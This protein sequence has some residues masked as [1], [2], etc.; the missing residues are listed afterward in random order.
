MFFLQTL[1]FNNLST[2]DG[3]S[4]NKVVSVIQD[5]TGFLWFGTEDG[6]NRFDGY[7]FKVFR[8]NPADSNSI[9]SNNIWSLFEDD[10]GNIWIGT[11]SGE[12]N[13]Y[14][15]K[16]DIFE[17][18][19][20]KS[21][22][23]Q[24]NSIN[25]IYSDKDG[26]VWIGSYQSGLYRF[27]IKTGELKNWNYD[28]GDPHSLS[29]NFVTS[30]IE[31]NFG[32][33]WIATYNGLNK[34][35]PEAN[36]DSFTQFY[37][38]SKNENSLSSNL[39]WSI[40]KSEFDPNLMWLGTANGLVSLN[41][42]ENIFS[43]IPLSE[44]KSLQ[45]GNSVSYVVEEKINNKTQLWVGTYGGLVKLDM[46]N[47]VSQ[48]FIKREN[49]PTSIINNQINRTI[50][51]RSGVIWIATEN[52]ISSISTKGF[53]FNNYFNE[54][55]IAGEL[56]NLLEVN[57]KCI[58]QNRNGSVF[59][60]TSD[61]IYSIN[62]FDKQPEFKKF[63]NTNGLNVWS[64]AVDVSNNLW[65][66]T[67]GQGLKKLNL[68]S[69]TLNNFDIE[70]PTFKTSAFD[71]L[72][73]LFIDK[74]NKLWIG[75]WGG[76]LARL[77]PET[78]EYKIWITESG[79]PK[80]ISHNDVWAIHQDGKGRIWIGTNGGG[81]NLAYLPTG[82]AGRQAGLFD[83]S[84]EGKFQR[85]IEVRNKSEQLSSNSIYSICESL[86]GK[87]SQ[88]DET[89]L[90]IGTSNGLNK[91]IIKNSSNLFDLSLLDVEVNYYS[92]QNGLA[93]N[94]VKSILEDEN[95]NLWIGT[96]SGISFFNVESGSFINY[97]NSDGVIGNDFNSGSALFSDAGLMFFGSAIGLNIF[98]PNQIK[99]SSYKPP[100]VFTDF[101][102]FNQPVKIGINSVLKQSIL[103]TKEIELAYSQNVFSFQFSA[104]DYNSPQS[105]QYAYMMEGF[106]KDWIY[107]EHRRFITYTNLDP[108]GYIFKVKSTNSDGVWNEDFKYISVTINQPWWRT[109]WAY[110][111]YI[112]LIVVGIFSARKIERN[113][114]RITKRIKDA[115]V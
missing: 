92:T 65:I 17:H 79:N 25:E 85:W 26:I 111:I 105:I 9:S 62:F 53:K 58:I 99:Q 8:N 2:K 102:I 76:G 1:H 55:N 14:D 24:E 52:G 10:E 70:S 108:G 31:D 59:F 114:S 30:I 94:A 39:I 89:I 86:N 72:K 103:D 22:N 21:E 57:V 33:L 93:D 13:R 48:R 109:G 82:Q 5:K 12:L 97:S 71:Y 63:N 16:K 29:N 15:V 23:I 18:W 49:D 19:K 106:D 80:S 45:F 28:P 104:L 6:L 43:K 46:V 68:K 84:G 74:Y 77:I 35:N 40:K 67:Y 50:R 73:S 54:K 34:F 87:L 60:G 112:L 95:G 78:G 37:A 51:D 20:I 36:D 81:L 110:T 66:G 27:N 44:D 38:H 75:F 41:L 91:V 64:L 47:G 96:N 90:W 42:K 7:E 88:S 11:K 83:Y 113:R 107:P 115:R 98:D 101:Q 69:L 56:K 100:I 4:N 32:Y 61:G 3:L